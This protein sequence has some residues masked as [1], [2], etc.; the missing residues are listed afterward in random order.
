MYQFLI[1]A[2]LFTLIQT[3]K[4]DVQNPVNGLRQIARILL[5][6]GSQQTY[7]TESLAKR[8]N[9]KLGDKDEFML[10]TFGSE[11]PKRTES[12]NTKLD[13]VLKDG[14]ILTIR[15][16]VVPQIAESI[17]RR[18]VNLKSLDN[19]DCLWNEFSLA[20]DIPTERET[21]SVELLIGNN[22]YLDIILPQKVEV[23]SGL[24]MLGSKL[25]WNLS[26][27][28]SEI[29]ENSTESSMP[30]MT[31]GKGIDNETTFLTCLD[32]SL[33]MKPNLE[34]FWK[35]ESIG[36]SDS[37]VESDN[38]VALKKFNETLKYDE[39]RYTV[40]WPW[41]EE[42]PDLPDNRALALGRLKSLVS[43]MRNNPEL[44][45]KYED[46]ITDQ[47]EKG[48]I[49]KVGSESNR[50]F[51]AVVNPT[52]ATTKVRVVYDAS[53]KCRSE[54]RSLNEC[55]HRG[56]ILLQNLTGILHRFRLNKIAMVADIEKAFLQ[57]R[58]QD[59]AK[60]VTRFFWLK[61]RDK[62]EVENNIQM[63]RFCMVPFGMISSPFLLAATN[64][65]HL[66][67]C[68]NDVS[69]TIRKN[70]Y[71]DNVITGTQSCQEAVHLYNVSNQ[72]FKGAAMNLWDWMTNSQEVLNEIPT[73]DRANRENMKVLGLTWFVKED[74]LVINSQIKDEHIVSKRT[75]LRQIASVY[76]PLGLYSPVTLR[77]KLF[78]QG[79]WNQKIAW[80]KHLSERD[81]IQWYGIHEDLKLLANCQ[82]PRH[83]GL[84][85]KGSTKYQL[86]VFCDASRYAFAAAVYLIQECQ[87][88]RRTDLIFS[89]TRLV[90]NKK[91]TIPRLELLA[92]LIGTRCMKF[93]ENELKVEICQKHIWLDS[94]CV[95][96]WIQSERPLGT[97]VE[98]RV[99]EIK[100][101]KDINF[102]YIS[103][104]EN[105]ADKA[106]RGTS[107]RELR[108]DRIWW[109]G[110]EWLV[111]TQQT[112]P[113]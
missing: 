112:W 78:L 95:L 69:E 59:G 39:G 92:A 22:Y 91:I 57:I 111:Q 84:D 4:A 68:N 46:I 8:L 101:D 44:I 55:L 11:K 24:Y 17:Q 65:H 100:T 18:P 106:S 75:V 1:I 97:F 66:K 62:L 25:G 71:V 30:I 41:K 58:L 43:R 98:N 47:R 102:H 16:N 34:D 94:Q 51:H 6:S 9:L 110:P 21:S 28:T 23:Q 74:C 38:D 90:P 49:E 70:I 67:N 80:D 93:V 104:T 2:Y 19:W 52:K 107:T 83:I 45:Q 76:D 48:I 63:Y 50:L 29:V 79:L 32:K 105:P 81:R 54:N 72:V 7:I 3:A 87:A 14:S 33:P 113:E 53:A 35:L 85:K 86:L 88:Q 13:I 27:R 31:H 10:V 40:T 99:K 64:D 37:P 12:R 82:F 15:A 42:Q 56:P 60:D 96:N 108:D 26:G 20:D 61:D 103:T 73:H 36:I 77:G 109:H 5:D 89:K